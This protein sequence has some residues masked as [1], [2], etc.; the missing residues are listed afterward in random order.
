MSPATLDR[1]LR[2][3]SA[4]LRTERACAAIGKPVHAIPERRVARWY[5]WSVN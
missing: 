3:L 1:I 2:W 5:T 4:A